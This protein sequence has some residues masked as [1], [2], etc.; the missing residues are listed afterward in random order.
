MTKCSLETIVGLESFFQ[1]NAYKIK[2]VEFV[3]IYKMNMY[4]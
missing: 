4:V 3:H 1:P 2:S